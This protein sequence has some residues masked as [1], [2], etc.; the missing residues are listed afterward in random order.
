MGGAQ[1]TRCEGGELWRRH[2]G[3]ENAHLVQANMDYWDHDLAHDTQESL[4]RCKVAVEML[5]PSLERGY[6]TES[7]LWSLLWQ[8]PIYERGFTLYCTVMHPATGSF[9]S[10]SDPPGEPGPRAGARIC[11]AARKRSKK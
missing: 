9:R 2:L 3:E 5:R 7:E 4:T 6:A 11:I 1:I 8:H 10:L